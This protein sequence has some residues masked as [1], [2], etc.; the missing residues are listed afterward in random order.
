MSREELDLVILANIQAC[1]HGHYEH[2]GEKRSRSPRYDTFVIYPRTH[3][4]K[5]RMPSYTIPFSTVEDI[6]AFMSNYVEENR[7]LLPGRIPGYKNDDIKLLPSC[8][9]KM[10]VWKS[11]SESCEAAK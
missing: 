9:S 11:Y 4:N 7:V 10:N 5:R 8:E 3:G 1:T 6:Q 2:V